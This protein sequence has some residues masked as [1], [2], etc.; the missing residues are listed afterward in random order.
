MTSDAQAELEAA[1][2]QLAEADAARAAAMERITAAVQAAHACEVPIAHIAN[3]TGL[4]RVT[5]YRLLEKD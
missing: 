2:K 4:S 3:A 5:I 1:G